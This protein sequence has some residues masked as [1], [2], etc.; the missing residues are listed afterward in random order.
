[1]RIPSAELSH[2]TTQTT[3]THTANMSLLSLLLL[4]STLLAAAL[5][6]A[7]SARPAPAAR[8][9]NSSGVE[10]L[11]ASYLPRFLDSDLATIFANCLV[12]AVEG[13]GLRTEQC[14]ASGTAAPST[15]CLPFSPF[16]TAQHTG[17]GHP[18]RVSERHI[19]HHWRHPCDVAARLIKSGLPIL[20]VRICR[21][22][23]S[24]YAARHGHEACAKC[25]AGP[26]R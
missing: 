22:R 6:A 24:R 10:A 9:F 3:T 8:T 25:A 20:S 4:T 16:A 18:L 15:S 23:S 5:A 13:E 2:H 1:M 12:R 19:H 17:H 11:I 7:P 26:L 14:G 21:R